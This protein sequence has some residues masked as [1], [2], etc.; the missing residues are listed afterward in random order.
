MF[1]AALHRLTWQEVHWFNLCFS[2]KSRQNSFNFPYAQSFHLSKKCWKASTCKSTGLRTIGILFHVFRFISPHLP[3]SY[4]IKLKIYT[5]Y[6]WS[7][8]ANW[9]F[10]PHCLAGQSRTNCQRMVKAGRDL[11]RSSGL[12]LCS[13]RGFV[14]I[15]IY[16]STV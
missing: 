5:Y 2:N 10:F 12:M 6:N 4:I 11:W 9:F 1:P 8:L 14:Y 15:I 13:S 3:I 7:Q 16:T